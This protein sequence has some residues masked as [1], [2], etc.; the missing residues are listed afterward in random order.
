MTENPFFQ[1]DE[2]EDLLPRSVPARRR[3]IRRKRLPGEET[4]G[5]SE[6]LLASL[7][8]LGEAIGGST[9]GGALPSLEGFG[10]EDGTIP[11]GEYQKLPEVKASG[12]G[13][14]EL[15]LPPKR[16]WERELEDPQVASRR[17]QE[18]LDG[19]S[20]AGDFTSGGGGD[21]LQEE[22]DLLAV[23]ESLDRTSGSGTPAP[24]G[25]GENSF[26]AY[27]D[28]MEEEGEEDF[29]L[30]FNID[31]ILG[32]AID[33][34]ASDVHISSDMTVAFT[35]LGDILHRPNIPVPSGV[36]T[37]RVFQSIVSHVLQ[38]DFV[39]DLELDTSYVIRTGAHKGRRLR[40]NVGKSFQEVFLVFRVISDVI[41]TPESLGVNEEFLEWVTLP[42]GLIM[43]NGTTGSGKTTT[44]ASLLRRIQ[45]TRPQKIVTLEKPVEFI[46]G[47][48]GLAFITQREIGKDA[49]SFTTAITSAMRQAPDIIMVGEVRNRM[50]VNELLRAAETG[51]L[52]ISTMHT[53]SVAVTVS[54]IASLYEGDDRLRVLASLGDNLRGMANQVLVKNPEGT[55]RFA[56]REILSMNPTVAELVGRGDARGVRTYQEDLGI[57]MEHE[58]AKAVAQGKC[59]PE[60]A[61]L[62]TAYPSYLRDL[63]KK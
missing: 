48:E 45:L 26:E 28:Y 51:H 22:E 19:G 59:T 5:V 20:L 42:S 44:L 35:H 61:L 16:E 53:N 33:L 36:V 27:Q 32:E 63:L 41:P 23:L 3:P 46:F 11:T 40:L 2:Q 62:H 52:T 9:L 10:D 31:T 34:G 54:R 30:G 47:Q 6:D 1:D 43:L 38:D 60:T 58:L 25:G 37:Q 29:F 39:V 13:G 12:D 50:E 21:P 4:P 57:T 17:V 56:V 49:R 8:D 55:G 14:E 7:P 24:P 15:F 18:T